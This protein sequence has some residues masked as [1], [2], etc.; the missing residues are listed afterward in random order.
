MKKRGRKLLFDRSEGSILRGMHYKIGWLG[1]WSVVHMMWSSFSSQF[2][3]GSSD[4]QSSKVL[5]MKS[6]SSNMTL[7]DLHSLKC[8]KIRFDTS[9]FF[10]SRW[11]RSSSLS[12]FILKLTSSNF[13]ENLQGWMQLRILMLYSI[14]D[15]WGINQPPNHT[16]ISWRHQIKLSN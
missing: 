2:C 16:R 1:S 3:G 13:P 8:E 15:I 4:L 10:N 7:Y 14:K 9:V 6:S 11:N 5:E 12:S